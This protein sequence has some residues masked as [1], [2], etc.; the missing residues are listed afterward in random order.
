MV[1]NMTT[2]AD[3]LSKP[4]QPSSS[5]LGLGTSVEQNKTNRANEI[6]K[7]VFNETQTK[8]SKILKYEK[9]IER[10][11]CLKP[12]LKLEKLRSLL[13]IKSTEYEKKQEEIE[14]IRDEISNLDISNQNILYSKTFEDLDRPDRYLVIRNNSESANLIK[15][16]KLLVVEEDNL[17]K[18]VEEYE[19]LIEAENANQSPAAVAK[20]IRIDRRIEYIKR[21]IEKISAPQPS[22]VAPSSSLLKVPKGKM[23]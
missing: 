23:I 6:T 1:S 11:K 16:L 3:N 17:K 2:P 20:A 14:F 8:D 10:L 12:D 13:A 21:Q 18:E 5:N 19:N 7:N 22:E 15:N 4:L 9:K